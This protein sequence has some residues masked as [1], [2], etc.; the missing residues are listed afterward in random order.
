M[1]LIHQIER[2]GVRTVDRIA[3]QPVPKHAARNNATPN[4]VVQQSEGVAQQS[5][6]VVAALIKQVS[7]LTRRVETLEVALSGPTEPVKIE[8]PAK[9]SRAEYFR[10]RR[11]KEKAAKV[12]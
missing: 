1:A 7:E 6:T 5:K 9:T 8:K 2:N 4:P 3:A 11:K 12:A 10:E